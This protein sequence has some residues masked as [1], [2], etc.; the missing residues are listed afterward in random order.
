MPVSWRTMPMMITPESANIETRATARRVALCQ[1]A[2]R[3]R[4]REAGAACGWGVYGGGTGAD[5][6]CGGGWDGYTRR[7]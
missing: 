5:G 2:V 3:W 1:G 6:G 7:P 4:G